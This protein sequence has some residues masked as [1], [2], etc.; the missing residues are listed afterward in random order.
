MHCNKG[1][2]LVMESKKIIEV[3]KQT[4]YENFLTKIN[5]KCISENNL[6]DLIA[7]LE[8]TDDSILRNQIALL[9]SDIG[10]DRAVPSLLSL[11]SKEELKNKRG[12]LIYC[13]ANL[14]LTDEQ[15]LEV[16][17]LLYQGNYE[18]QQETYELIKKKSEQLEN[19][20]IV[21]LLIT[22]QKKIQQYSNTLSIMEDVKE[23]LIDHLE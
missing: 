11:I 23:D 2:H 7:V 14:S 16:S 9:L 17:P 12:T 21:Q 22:L 15:I 1:A 19:S 20:S 6:S 18:V 10:C 13:L 4:N 3:L 8:T 5:L